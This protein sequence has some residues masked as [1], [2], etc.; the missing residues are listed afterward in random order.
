MQQLVP[1]TLVL[2]HTKQVV[3]RKEFENFNSFDD[4]L[5]NDPK[6]K[7]FEVNDFVVPTIGFALSN[8]KSKVDSIVGFDWVNDYRLYIQGKDNFRYDVYS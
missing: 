3:E 7:N 5:L 6:G 2:L 8:V 4:F 1:K